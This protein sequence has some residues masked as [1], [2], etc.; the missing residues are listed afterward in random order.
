MKSKILEIIWSIFGRCH[1][2][3]GKIAWDGFHDYCLRCGTEF[4]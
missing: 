1:L 2:C 3:G 4:K